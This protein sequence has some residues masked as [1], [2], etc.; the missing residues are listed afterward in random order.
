MIWQNHAVAFSLFGLDVRWYGISY[1]LG[2]FLVTYL[3]WWIFEK[4]KQ[5]SDFFAGFK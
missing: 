2:F 3:G 4:I 1:I 5:N